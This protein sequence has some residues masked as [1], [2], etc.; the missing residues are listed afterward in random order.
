MKKIIFIIL[1]LVIFLSYNAY[2]LDTRLLDMRN[3]IFEEAKAIKLLLPNSKDAPLLIS[4]WDSCLI[5]IM[6]LDA[7][8]SMLGIFNTIKGEDLNVDAINYIVSW[9]GEIK[10]TT[11][12]NIK[13]LNMALQV[14]E[15]NTKNHIEKLKILFSD[16][17]K[18][19]DIENNKFFILMRSLRIKG[20]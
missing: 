1:S 14:L 5:A 10:S 18:R 6:Q 15:Q 2:A 4:M 20:K 3:K 19:I 11:D 17:N 12:L 7:Y 8:F 13:N 16:F 9:L